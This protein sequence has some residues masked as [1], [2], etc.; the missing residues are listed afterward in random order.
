MKN[1]IFS[2][3]CAFSLILSTIITVI[4]FWCFN[5]AFYKHEYESLNT[6][7]SIGMSKDDL[8]KTT[9]VLLSYIKDYDKTLDINVNINGE[10][11][12]V[13][14]EREKAHMID[15]R[16]LYQNAIKVRN[17]SLLIY[18]FSLVILIMNKG[19]NELYRG[20]KK[21]LGTFVVMFGLIAFF[22]LIDFNSFW[23]NFHHV[24]FPSNDLWLLD[25]RTDI[26]IM[27]VPE[28]FFFDLCVLIIFSIFILMLIF[29]IIIKLLDKRVFNK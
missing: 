17:F 25:P 10:N 26:L 6:A 20:F 13:F 27:M 12:Q 8:N 21:A 16:D 14:N 7:S 3:I 24:F 23:I 18:A 9:D 28:K 29:F 2:L 5:Y 22:C 19:L 15:V 1:R 11:R 4:D